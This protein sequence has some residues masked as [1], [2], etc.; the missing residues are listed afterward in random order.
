MLR[1]RIRSIPRF[2]FPES[3]RSLTGLNNIN[4]SSSFHKNPKHLSKTFTFFYF[5]KFKYVFFSKGTN[6]TG[7]KWQGKSDR[8][9]WQGKS[10]REKVTGKKWLGKSDKEKLPGKKWQRQSDSNKVTAKKIKIVLTK[11][12]LI[13]Y[14]AIVIFFFFS[15]IIW[16]EKV[17][18][19]IF[20][21]FINVFP[22]S[23]YSTG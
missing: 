14:L 21:F 12:G 10:D 2:F 6:T 7:K 1:I 5:C 23:I 9:K 3:G 17:S 13:L 22:V 16:T 18:L 20:P 4:F 11:V 19:F 8:E 15:K